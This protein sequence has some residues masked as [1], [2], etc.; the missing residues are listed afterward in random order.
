MRILARPV[1]AKKPRS[2]LAAQ[3]AYLYAGLIVLMV[4]AQLFSFDGFLG[5]LATY[6]L[7]FTVFSA[8]MIGALLVS[9]SVFALPFL[10]RM[11]VSEAFRAFSM[12]CSWLVAIIWILLVGWLASAAPPVETV[13]F[14]G[15]I[16]LVPGW[17]MIFVALM[18]GILAVWSSWGLWP[19][20]RRAAK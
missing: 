15:D 9:S 8:Y 14:L 4:V 11:T 1:Q 13:G 16:S 6:K 19:G 2:V 5:V 17:W 20:K 12:V 3:V 10:L 7:P 18:L